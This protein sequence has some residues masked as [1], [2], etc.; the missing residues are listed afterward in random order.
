MVLI[1][2]RETLEEYSSEIIQLKK[3]DD[4]LEKTVDKATKRRKEINTRIKDI[5]KVAG[6]EKERVILPAG[7]H[8]AWDRVVSRL[9]KGLNIEILE[10]I[11]GVDKFR[12]LCCTKQVS[13]V[14]TP[15]KIEAARLMGKIS[16]KMM[17]EAYFEGNISY[18]LKKMNTKQYKKHVE[19]G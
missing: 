16:D 2:D 13:Y 1:M 7:E 10:N 17:E 6:S 11:L 14:P 3:E 5:A 8:G 12:R 4:V 9:G 19:G 18:S 15:E